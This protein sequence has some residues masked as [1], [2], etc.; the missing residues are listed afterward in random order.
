MQSTILVGVVTDTG[1]LGPHPAFVCGRK[2]VDAVIHGAGGLAL[3]LPT[4]TQSIDALLDTVDGLL[5][6]GSYS[7]IDPNLYGANAVPASVRPPKRDPDRD[8]IALPLLRAAIDN[9]TPVLA[10]CRG[11]QELNVSLGG[12]LHQALHVLPDH[13]D[14]RDTDKNANGR[15][16]A[17]TG[18]TAAT[19][20]TFA[21]VTPESLASRYGPSHPVHLTNGGLLQN[22]FDTDSCEV[23]SLHGQ[24]IDRLAEGLVV[25][26]LAPDGV[27]EAVRSSNSS[28]FA[29]GVQW[30]PE[31]QFGRNP[32]SQAL[33]SAF[34]DA[35]RRYRYGRTR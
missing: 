33:F 9:G 15:A 1:T 12:T 30:H 4:V 19:P 31:W 16:T 29:V 13:L 18:S 23:N 6:T 14:H 35:C 22:L 5:F 8:A 26:A 17:A 27:I 20:N 32:Q 10:I 28:L 2:Y 21:D 25:E 7:D 11:L 24:G 34:G 3:L